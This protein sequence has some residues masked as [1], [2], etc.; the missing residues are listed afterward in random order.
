[1]EIR[2]ALMENG[3]E[4]TNG[5]TYSFTLHPGELAKR[6]T[7]QCIFRRQECISL[8]ITFSNVNGLNF[9]VLSMLPFDHFHGMRCDVIECMKEIGISMLR[10]PGGNFAGEYRWQDGLLDADERAPLEAYM[11]NETQPLYQRI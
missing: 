9:G 5:L 4:D 7:F 8:S 11:E 10:W 2:V 6:E 3:I 1:M